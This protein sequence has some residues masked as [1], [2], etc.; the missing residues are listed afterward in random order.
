MKKLCLFQTTKFGMEI[1]SL[2]QL[3][4]LNE[5][6]IVPIKNDVILAYHWPIKMYT[7]LSFGNLVCVVAYHLSF[8]LNDVIVYRP[9]KLMILQNFNEC[10]LI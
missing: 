2:N 9:Y 4:L 10:L 1:K 3:D 5:A 8:V 6:V 7:D